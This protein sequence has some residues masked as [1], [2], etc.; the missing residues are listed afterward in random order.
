MVQRGPKKSETLEVRVS[1]E[2]KTKLAN[3]AKQEGLTLSALVRHLIDRELSPI[4]D[5]EATPTFDKTWKAKVMT[6]IQTLTK[7]P[8][9]LAGSFA[10]LIAVF[11][12]ANSTSMADNFALEFGGTF[13]ESEQHFSFDHICTIDLGEGCTFDIGGDGEFVVKI[14]LQPMAQ[15]QQGDVIVE[16]DVTRYEDQEGVRKARRVTSPVL[17]SDFDVSS[18]VEMTTKEGNFY[19]MTVLTKPANS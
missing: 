1:F 7:R 8:R 9:L 2:T 3:K 14:Q 15:E 12:M 13:I 11:M 4:A 17:I 18:R 10:S 16:I 5:T 19:S 6:Q